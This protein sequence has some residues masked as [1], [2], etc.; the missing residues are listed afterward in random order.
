MINSTFG[1]LGSWFGQEVALNCYFPI[2]ALPLRPLLHDRSLRDCALLESPQREVVLFCRT[3]LRE[4][5]FLVS[6]APGW[7]WCRRSGWRRTRWF[8]R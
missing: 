1:L 5:L 4:V 6:D 3:T 7:W 2:H 8:A